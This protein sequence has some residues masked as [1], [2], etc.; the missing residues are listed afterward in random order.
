MKTP[1][2]KNISYNAAVRRLILAT[3]SQKKPARRLVADPLRP[4]RTN[5]KQSQTKPN[6]ISYKNFEANF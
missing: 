4:K 3:P 5:I 6:Y 2:Y 1:F